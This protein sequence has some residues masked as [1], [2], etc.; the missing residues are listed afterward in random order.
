[1]DCRQHQLDSIPHDEVPFN[2]IYITQSSSSNTITVW[3]D[4]ITRRGRRLLFPTPLC[5]SAD[6]ARSMQRR[7]Q[8]LHLHSP[9]ANKLIFIFFTG[10][11][12]FSLHHIVDF[13]CGIPDAD[14]TIVLT[15]GNGHNYVTRW[16]G[17][18]IQSFYTFS[19]N[20]LFI[21]IYT[22]LGHHHHYHHHHPHHHPH[23]HHYK[24]KDGNADCSC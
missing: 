21:Y 5:C 4:L 23:N 17:G 12:S 24:N 19:I 13:T 2:H 1:M 14:D 18:K 6:L 3:R 22:M 10:G 9:K 8:V 7:C 15:G 11:G 16:V 20:R